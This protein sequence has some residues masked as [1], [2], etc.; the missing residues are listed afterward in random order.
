LPLPN[1][2]ADSESGDAVRPDWARFQLTIAIA[3]HRGREFDK[4]VFLL[5]GS[6]SRP[7]GLPY[8]AVKPR[9][10]WARFQ[11]TIAIVKHRVRN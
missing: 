3:K 11:L 7:A 4:A 5:G 10:D 8:I 2:E 9:P 1:T 6:C